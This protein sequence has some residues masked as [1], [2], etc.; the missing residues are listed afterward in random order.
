[1]EIILSFFFF[2]NSTLKKLRV[3]DCSTCHVIIYVRSFEK[4][5]SRLDSMFH[6]ETSCTVCIYVNKYYPKSKKKSK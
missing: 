2:L 4:D 3:V 5:Y 1:M 6:H